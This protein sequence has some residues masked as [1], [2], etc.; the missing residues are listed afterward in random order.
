MHFNN[1]NYVMHRAKEQGILQKLW[2]KR[3]SYYFQS[4]SEIAYVLVLLFIKSFDY[5][6]LDFFSK[7]TLSI[8][9]NYDELFQSGVLCFIF[10]HCESSC[11]SY[12][13]KKPQE[14]L[15]SF[16]KLMQKVMD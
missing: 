3:C 2:M 13:R 14:F 15:N 10:Q 9:D 1:Y 7:K 11:E 16:S 5:N 8:I 6:Q 12:E 4:L